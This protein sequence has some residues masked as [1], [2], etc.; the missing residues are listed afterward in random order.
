MKNR[1]KRKD[2]SK[3]TKAIAM[4]L[5]C[6]M[7]F[8]NT[9]FA[10][11]LPTAGKVK[12]GKATISVAG[13][14]MTIKQFSNDLSLAWS[15]FNIGKYQTVDFLQPN[16]SSVALNFISTA[17]LIG[18]KLNANGQVFLIDPFG[19]I[20]GKNAQ[21]NVGGLVAAG[22]SLDSWKNGVADFSGT[23]NVVNEG[24][25]T[26]A[27]GGYIALVGQNTSNT[28]TMSSR[29]GTVA[30]AAGNDVSLDFTKNSLINI[31]VDKNTLESTVDN[32]G[33][34][35]A[36]GGKILLSAGAKDSLV[37]S[38]VNNTGVIDAN[39]VEND[40]GKVSLLAG[41][42][43]GTVNVG[44]TIDANGSAL[45]TSASSVR[46]A[47]N[48]QVSTG[49]DGS[50]LIDPTSYYIGGSSPDIT[51]SQLDSLLASNNITIS[52]TQGSGGTNGNIYVDS[53]LTW[54]NNTL[55]L[56]AYNNILFNNSTIDITGTGALKAYANDTAAFGVGSGNGIIS[57]SGSSIS[58]PSGTVEFFYNP[59][60]YSSPTS[61]SGVSA[62]TFI[63]Y[64]YIN[65]LADLENLSS[66]QTST[67]LANSYA[68]NNNIGWATNTT[69]NFTP[70][71]SLTTPFSGYFDGMGH[72]INNL[73]EYNPGLV[74]G[75]FGSVNAQTGSSSIPALRNVFLTNENI[76]DTT[77][78]TSGYFDYQYAGGL[79]GSIACGS[80]STT[81]TAD[82]ISNVSTSGSLS[83]TVNDSDSSSIYAQPYTGG[84]AGQVGSA[85]SGTSEINNSSSSMI[86]TANYNSTTGANMTGS[87]GGLVGYMY[88]NITNAEHT[89]GVTSN[90]SSD[91]AYSGS[92]AIAEQ[93]AGGLVGYLDGS[94]S[95]TA[96]YAT[97]SYL[98]L[99][100]SFTG[101]GSSTGTAISQGDLGGLI[102]YAAGGT[103][104]KS[105]SN[106]GIDST[107]SGTNVFSVAGGLVGVNTDAISN[108]F[109]GP[110]I[111][112]NGNWHNPAIIAISASSGGLSAAGG[113]IGEETAT[114]TPYT[115][116]DTYAYASASI[117]GSASTAPGGYIGWL[118]SSYSGEFSNDYWNTTVGGSTG[119]GG[120][121]TISG[122]SGLT[123]SQM[124]S[125]SNFAGFTFGG[126]PW[127][128]YTY[129]SAS[130]SSL[131]LPTLANLSPSVGGNT[132]RSTITQNTPASSLYALTVSGD[133]IS[134]VYDGTTSATITGTPALSGIL[135]TD[136][137][138]SLSGDPTSGSYASANVGNDIVISSLN[139]PFSLSGSDSSMYALAPL[140]GQITPKDLGLS[141][142]ATKTYDG[143][144]AIT[145][146]SS[147]TSLTGL[148]SGQ[149][150]T[151]GYQSNANFSTANAGSNLGGIV[152]L[153]K[154]N[155]TGNTA[156]TDALAAGDYVLPSTFSGGSITP[157]QL[158]ASTFAS[159]TYDGNASITLNGS[160]TTLNGFISGQGASITSP[161]AGTFS[162]ANAGNN[163]G[164]T[165]SLSSSNTTANSG[166][167]LSNYSLPTTFTGGNIFQRPLTLTTT[168][169]SVYNGSANVNLTAS[170][171]SFSGFV[172]GQGGHLNTT[173]AG[174]YYSSNAGSNIG[175]T[176]NLTSSEISP[177]SGTLLSNYMLP[178]YF[179]G[180]T[181]TPA[182]LLLTGMTAN[183]KV[184]DGTDTATL[185]SLGTL[186]GLVSG[187]TLT[188][189]GPSSVFFSSP[190]VGNNKTV[191]ADGFYVTN[192]S[193]LASN[194]TLAPNWTT[195]ADITPAPLSVYF[196]NPTKT[197]NG[198]KTIDLN[199][200]NVELVGFVP[201]QTGVLN[202]D[203]TFAT[204]KVGSNI[205]VTADLTNSDFTL[206]PGTSLSNYSYPSVIS[207]F[208]TI[209][210]KSSGVTISPPPAYLPPT[211][212]SNNPTVVNPATGGSGFPTAGPTPAGDTASVSPDSNNATNSNSPSVVS[213][214]SSSVTLSDTAVTSVEEK[215]CISPKS[216]PLPCLSVHAHK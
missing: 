199:S 188:L 138:V 36:N 65:S 64:L 5:A 48:A 153:Y 9:G 32:A 125:S 69:Y 28:G 155:V 150:G 183:N 189:N 35:G 173:V 128:M 42:K 82:L 76:S 100:A 145:L 4:V 114:N 171:T 113:L 201:G 122:L 91:A 215:T 95:H 110:A 152:T 164:G 23:G 86:V 102:G 72:T 180:G 38:A 174:T 25:I 151:A 16:S 166:T 154:P 24:T 190:S 81:S 14:T 139:S 96:Q 165:L 178:T 78:F 147:N 83:N 175:G 27:P 17:S 198:T 108:S 115:L 193:G 167:L 123:T 18:G 134:K 156:F 97:P 213:S 101:S 133:T 136:S 80:C 146:T 19:I 208:G 62:G 31:N 176:D 137:S 126:S 56:K 47:K 6:A 111:D 68:L 55:T 98:N 58:A 104:S 141:T 13:K 46:I 106:F 169:S 99:N 7:T 109:V 159:K 1:I 160:D 118:P 37:A 194:Y 135:P 216:I 22:M 66:T 124:A 206:S 2:P 130:V 21:I 184:Y 195:T 71:G 107:G 142:T 89:G 53:N 105:F 144:S 204:D 210:S 157:A 202:V 59:S 158:T 85:G 26:T 200:S 161:V 197:Y 75:L 60:S 177:S 39:A 209:L 87:T 179:F 127:Q 29:L 15:S 12:S 212:I 211:P 93:Y 182:P 131:Q 181:I 140:V 170:N 61:F 33:V 52:S 88:G 90:V 121:G 11:A 120:A 112:T 45:D 148:V 172:S 192:G 205:P 191:F 57:M 117:S 149:T 54:A 132:S 77:S 207:G 129:S 41:T 40:K 143:S 73:Y 34:I 119:V 162:T 84:I 92:S 185:S 8:G 50:W 103:I 10:F 3:L 43:T 94:A 74:A 168:A 196:G 116:T 51:G 187:Q 79:V 163:L 44:G 214:S 30:M 49:A 70:I 67:T 63:P 186:S 203:G 20:F